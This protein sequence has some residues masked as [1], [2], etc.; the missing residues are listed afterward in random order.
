MA[1]KGDLSSVQCGNR[2]NI[3][4]ELSAGHIDNQAS[5]CI[6]VNGVKVQL[7]SKVFYGR[8]RRD[9][10]TR[11]ARSSVGV[12]INSD[13]ARGVAAKSDDFGAGVCLHGQRDGVSGGLKF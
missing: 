7:V 6:R 12:D 9:T 11:K 3:I 10:G 4:R 5:V 2:Q 13:R 1:R 8:V